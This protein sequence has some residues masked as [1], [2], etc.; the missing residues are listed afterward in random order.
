MATGEFVARTTERAHGAVGTDLT[1]AH[2]GIV[3]GARLARTPRPAAR[4]A[5]AIAI[6]R[7]AGPVSII[8]G[9]IAVT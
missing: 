5:V 1:V 6:A 7:D 3:T 8:S 9:L 2:E 4:P